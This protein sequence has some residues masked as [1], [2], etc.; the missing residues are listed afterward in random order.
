[1]MDV[2]NLSLGSD[3]AP[4]PEDDIL[5]SAIERAS[6]MGV[7]VVV[8]AGNNGPDPSTIGSPAIAPSAIAVGASSNDRIFSA[9]VSVEGV[10]AYAALPASGPTQV[11]A[12]RGSIVDVE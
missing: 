12:I 11:S 3:V 9:S 4:R 5:V 10:G 6:R 2:I 7:I 8:A 1:G